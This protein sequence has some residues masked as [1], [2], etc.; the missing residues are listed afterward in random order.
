MLLQFICQRVRR[1][2]LIGLN[3]FKY[4]HFGFH[5]LDRKN[6]SRRGGCLIRA[7]ILLRRWQN[8]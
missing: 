3:H 6:P 8:E 4:S 2:G 7:Q 5:G 1:L